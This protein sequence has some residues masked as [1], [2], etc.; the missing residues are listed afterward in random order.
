M[1]SQEK[2]SKE[3]GHGDIRLKLRLRTPEAVF[4]FHITSIVPEQYTVQDML[5]WCEGHPWGLDEAEL[6]SILL[7]IQDKACNTLEN[8]PWSDDEN[9]FIQAMYQ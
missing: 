3:Q 6:E 7:Q 8:W 9:E 4:L 2:V 5:A 1:L